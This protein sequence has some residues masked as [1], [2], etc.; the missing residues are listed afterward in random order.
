MLLKFSTIFIP[1]LL[2]NL[3][4]SIW[5]DEQQS[6]VIILFWFSCILL[7]R[8]TYYSPVQNQN[9]WSNLHAGFCILI[10]IFWTRFIVPENVCF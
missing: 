4:Y 3:F 8:P 2:E 6:E 9:Y 1:I 10:N 5:T 7:G